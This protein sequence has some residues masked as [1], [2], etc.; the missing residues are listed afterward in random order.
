VIEL[1]LSGGSWSEPH[2]LPSR[3]V[4][5]LDSHDGAVPEEVWQLFEEILPRCTQ[6]RGVTLERM[7]G[8]IDEAAV[9]RIRSELARAR[10]M[11]H[12]RR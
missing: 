11:L 5:R 6:L 12:A 9:P 10:E 1:H 3:A 4:L 8:T 7:E 2:W